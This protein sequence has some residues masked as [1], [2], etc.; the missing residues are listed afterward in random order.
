MTEQHK[1]AM[2]LVS[3]DDIHHDLLSA[4]LYF[5]RVAADAGFVARAAMGMQRF[6]DAFPLTDQQDLFCIYKAGGEFSTAQ[7]ASLAERV[8]NGAGLVALHCSNVMGTT[9]HGTLHPSFASYFHLLGNR[10]LSHGPGAHEGRHQ[11]RIVAE[12]PITAGV[13]DFELFDEYYEFEMADDNYELLAERTRDDGTVIPV[14]YTR[15]FGAGRVVYL[16]SG[17][18]LRAWGEPPFIRLVQQALVWAGGEG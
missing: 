12:H 13:T 9:E 16:A 18:D 1:N 5:Q 8:R 4:A 7:Q 14:L 10:Y 15:T 17:H 3:G 11:I 6:V 2:V